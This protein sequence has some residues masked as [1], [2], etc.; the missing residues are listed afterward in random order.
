MKN[1]AVILAGGVGSRMGNSMPK[2]FCEVAGRKVIEHT[3]DAFEKNRHIDEI[4]I[5]MHPDFIGMMEGI[6]LQNS[7]QKIKKILKGG[8]ERYMSTLSAIEAYR[9]EEELNLLFHDAVRPLVSQRIIDDVVAALDKFSA[10]DVTVPVTDT[11]VCVDNERE[12]VESIP[13]RQFLRRCQTPQAFKLSVIKEAYRRAMA[14]GSFESTDDCGMVHK[15]MPEVPIHMVPGSES[16]IKLTYKEDIF[17]IDR[18]FKLRET[19]S[20]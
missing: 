2:Q 11:I 14:E 5:V 15:Y 18:L 6:V 20:L 13:K 8:S 4:A 19:D 9:E 17:L 1:I 12:I 7:W 3:V 16:N 10:V